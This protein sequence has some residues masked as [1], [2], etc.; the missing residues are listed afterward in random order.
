ML[1][2]SRDPRS[3]SWRFLQLGEDLSQRPAGETA[4]NS[5]V[6]LPGSRRHEFRAGGNRLAVLLPSRLLG[7][8]YV[9]IGI[10]VAASKEYL[11]DFETV[12]RVLSAVLAIVL[13]PLLFLGIDLHVS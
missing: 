3:V 4:C 10:F 9:V 12:K 8:I 5:R 6:V 1:A 7:L 13:W 2:I 11:D